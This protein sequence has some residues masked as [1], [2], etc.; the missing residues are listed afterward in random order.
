M[1][2]LFAYKE[3]WEQLAERIDGIT[4]CMPVTVDD[5]MGKRLN[6]L[7]KNSVMLFYLPP[8]A[9]GDGHYDSFSE[10]NVCVIFIMKKYDPQR[11]SAFDALAETQP[12]IEAIKQ[13][14]LND[15]TAGCSPMRIDIATLN[16]I[17]ETEFYRSFAGWS[18]G[19]NAKSR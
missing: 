7:G 1:I 3:Y 4:G 11:E 18:L 2:N 12:I 13:A 16:T 17:P 6:S 10:K 8:S 9:S 19:F 5:E 14:M 15:L